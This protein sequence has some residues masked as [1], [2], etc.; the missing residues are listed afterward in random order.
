MLAHGDGKPPMLQMLEG[1]CP[2]LE[3]EFQNAV[4]STEINRRWDVDKERSDHAIDGTRYFVMGGKKGHMLNLKKK[5]PGMTFDHMMKRA[6]MERMGMTYRREV[7][8]AVP[9]G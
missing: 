5:Q 7:P 4:Y 1:E 9:L 2:N 3:R 8:M 6:K